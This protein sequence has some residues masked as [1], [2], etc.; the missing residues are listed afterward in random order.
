MLLQ[1]DAPL[2]V[3]PIECALTAASHAWNAALAT[4][5][6]DPEA[7]L[8]ACVVALLEVPLKAFTTI[9]ALLTLYD[10]PTR[11]LTERAIDLCQ[12]SGVDLNPR[13]ALDAACAL[14]LRL[15]MDGALV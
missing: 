7:Y 3:P 12:L 6:A 1:T 9:R 8:Y 4:A 2:S 5:E 10:T 15:L 13:V 14:R 11:A